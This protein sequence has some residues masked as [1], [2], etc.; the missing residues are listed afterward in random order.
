MT[1]NNTSVECTIHLEH[2]STIFAVLTTILTALSEF[3][4]FSKCKGNG[5]LHHLHVN[6]NNK[7]II[8]KDER[9]DA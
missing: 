7:R 9:V 3:M 5:L 4:P 2:L 6:V 8:A 1:L